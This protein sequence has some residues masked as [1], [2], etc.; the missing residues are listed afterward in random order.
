MYGHKFYVGFTKAEQTKPTGAIVI[1]S[2]LTARICG[3]WD[4]VAPTYQTVTILSKCIEDKITHISP[5]RIFIVTGRFSTQLIILQ[6]QFLTLIHSNCY[7]VFLYL[8]F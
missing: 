4:F 7:C 3:G 5:T 2:T 8:Q 6:N 1:K